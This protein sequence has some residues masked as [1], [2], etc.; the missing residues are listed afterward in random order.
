MPTHAFK[1]SACEMGFDAM[2]P[3]DSTTPLPVCPKC[4]GTDVRRV[5]TFSAGGGPRHHP[6]SPPPPRNV[7][8]RP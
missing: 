2:R 5:F 7:A 4:G 6:L 3:V 8:P 1:C